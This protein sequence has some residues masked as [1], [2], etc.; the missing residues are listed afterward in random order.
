MSPLLSPLSYRP[1]CVDYQV[2]EYYLG[3]FDLRF[4]RSNDLLEPPPDVSPMTTS[5]LTWLPTKPK[6]RYRHESVC[7]YARLPLRCKET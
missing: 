2:F 4:E 1:Y 3:S 7:H 5:P 6:W